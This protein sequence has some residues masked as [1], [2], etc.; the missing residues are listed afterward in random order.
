[1][2]DGLPAFVPGR[3]VRIP[4]GDLH[5]FLEREGLVIVGQLAAPQHRLVVE[6]AP[7]RTADAAISGSLDFTDQDAD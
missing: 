5:E 3:I 4:L 2:G 1:M 7:V 6:L